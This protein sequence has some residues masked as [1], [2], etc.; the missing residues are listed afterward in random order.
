MA[1]G[2]SLQAAAKFVAYLS[3]FVIIALAGYG[4]DVNFKYYS[5]YGD[6]TRIIIL[7]YFIIFAVIGLGTQFGV[8]GLVRYFRVLT[9]FVARA[10]LLFFIGTLGVSF[11]VRSTWPSEMNVP[12]A[13]GIYCLVAGTF[14]VLCI[15]FYD[16]DLD[17]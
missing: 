16:G 5:T 14:L 8:A 15:C 10:V 4:L 6:G 13:L 1:T 9:T 11:N 12:F 17:A 7:F 2:I 3:W